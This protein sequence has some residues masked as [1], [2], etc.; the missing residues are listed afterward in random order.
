MAKFR[1]LH[2]QLWLDEKFQSLSSQA[3]LLFVWMFTHPRSGLS[4][5][6]QFNDD[7]CENQTGLSGKEINSGVKEL[8]KSQRVFYD[9]KT[10]VLWVVNQF[11]YI[12]KS[13]KA[14]EA[15]LRELNALPETPL[16]Y[17]F[18]GHYEMDLTPYGI[19]INGEKKLFMSP[20]LPDIPPDRID[21]HRESVSEK[22]K[23]AKKLIG[24]FRVKWYDEY[25]IAMLVKSYYYKRIY[26]LLSDYSQKDIERAVKNYFEV[27]DAFIIKNKH[28]F[29][30]F[31]SNLDKYMAESSSRG[32]RARSK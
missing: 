14:I 16:T 18:L 30:L 23:Y 32:R 29:P 2:T 21:A 22:A 6:F 15:V 24:F 4:G 3:R 9:S 5:V 13:P 10:N 8:E 28:C 26:D 7:V 19:E 20:D 1:Q 31:L 17:Q 27:E 11:R 12:P 25:G